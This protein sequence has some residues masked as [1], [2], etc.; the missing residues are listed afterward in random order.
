M[1]DDNLTTDPAI[2]SDVARPGQSAPDA[3]SKPLIVGR[4]SMLKADPMMATTPAVDQQISEKSKQINLQPINKILKTPDSGT[5]PSD[6]AGGGLAVSSEI[7][8]VVDTV[9]TKKDKSDRAEA[10]LKR[11]EEVQ[12]LIDSKKYFVKTGFRSG[13]RN[14]WWLITAIVL[15]LAAAG[16]YF[17]VGPGKSIT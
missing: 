7:D 10:Q 15:L 5:R 12:R 11:D 14:L 3:T 16:W 9:S 13:R 17:M 1:A 2:I 6:D 4:G 8:A